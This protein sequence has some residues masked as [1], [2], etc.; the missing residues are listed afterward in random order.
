MINL[1]LISANQ[2]KNHLCKK[3][4]KY[5]ICGYDCNQFKH[6]FC[7]K[8]KEFVNDLLDSSK[9]FR[10]KKII[11]NKYMNNTIVGIP[12][13]DYLTEEP[14]DLTGWIEEP[15][16][17]EEENIMNGVNINHLLSA[18]RK[19]YVT[20]KV[21]FSNSNN[22]YTYKCLKSIQPEVDDVL[23]IQNPSGAFKCVTVIEVHDVPKI[24]YD[25]NINYKWIVCK[26][27]Q[28]QYNK[29]LEYEGGLKNKLIAL[30]VETKRQQ[31]L[32]TI[33]EASPELKVEL[34]SWIE[35][36]HSDE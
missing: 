29:L 36:E 6:G 27:Q 24:D 17:I 1:N 5:G 4:I 22:D 35:I 32:K 19:D 12:P 23:V 8:P 34:Q 26:V 30:E 31:Y 11:V 10:E 28:G 15:N 33:E 18:V 25:S 20:V 9:P 13:D 14:S 2:T 7:P 21:L 16:Y 3:L